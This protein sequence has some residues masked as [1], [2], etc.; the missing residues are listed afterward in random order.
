[1]SETR[2]A[3]AGTPALLVLNLL[4][5]LGWCG[6]FGTFNVWALSTGFVAGY[7]ALWLTRHLWGEQRG[8]YF[9]R[10]FA[11]FSFAL[12]YARAL[13]V[14]AW[15]VAK[16]VLSPTI[17]ARPGVIA[18]PLTAKRDVEIATLAN[19]VTLTP[20]TMSIDVSNDRSTLYVHVMLL[21]D[22]E[23]VEADI[24]ENFEARL[25]EVLR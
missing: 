2:S 21:D 19:L 11:G 15:E 17:T 1:M 20:G 3:A 16:Q 13:V 25:L 22:P 5:M 23:A 8:A 14:S 18:V 4:L 24:R 9:R 10:T 6:A 7:C 12:F